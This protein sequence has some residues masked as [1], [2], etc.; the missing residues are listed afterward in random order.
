MNRGWLESLARVYVI[1]RAVLFE[2]FDE[3][4]YTRFLNRH[5]MDS[6]PEAY[7]A[8]MQEQQAVKARRVRC[9]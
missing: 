9:C 5:S 6:T 2:L 3:A 4:A 7:R 1:V 8:F